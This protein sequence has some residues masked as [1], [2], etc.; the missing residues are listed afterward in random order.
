MSTE[1]KGTG[2]E[3]HEKVAVMRYEVYI[4]KGRAVCDLERVCRAEAVI[5]EKE[6]RVD[7]SRC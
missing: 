7:N 4:I 2:R 5:E 6:S 1:E 3:L